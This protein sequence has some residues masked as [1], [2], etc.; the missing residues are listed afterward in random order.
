MLNEGRVGG[1]S[2][3]EYNEN[4]RLKRDYQSLLLFVEFVAEI[5]SWLAGEG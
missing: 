4:L 5:M 1:H 2:E 3:R